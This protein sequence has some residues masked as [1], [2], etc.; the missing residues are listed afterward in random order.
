MEI[1]REWRR[2]DVDVPAEGEVLLLPGGSFSS[3]V[4][5]I[6]PDGLCFMAPESLKPG[7]EVRLIM[8]LPAIGKMETRVKVI[9]SGY[10]EQHKSYRAGGKFENMDCREKDKFLRFYHLKVMSLLGG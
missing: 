6:N 9:W 7:H 10:F 8:E 1:S 2:L 3:R 4:V 5:N